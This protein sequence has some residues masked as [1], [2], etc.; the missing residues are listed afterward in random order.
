MKKLLGLCLSLWITA[1]ILSG[2]G[3]SPSG[4]G[5][6]AETSGRQSVE[7]GNQ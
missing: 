7:A 5:S 6:M 2:C 3:A 4:S 1:T